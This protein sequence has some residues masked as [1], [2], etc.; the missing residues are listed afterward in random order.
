MSK[1]STIHANLAAECIFM[2]LTQ[3]T[4][5]LQIKKAPEDDLLYYKCSYIRL[6]E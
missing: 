1:L 5:Q 4:S 3:A 6:M 2:L